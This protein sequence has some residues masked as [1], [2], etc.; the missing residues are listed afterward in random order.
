MPL[1]KII[2]NA[3]NKN[4]NL[5]QNINSRRLSFKPNFNQFNNSFKINTN[6]NAKE[7][8]PRHSIFAFSPKKKMKITEIKQTNN[9]MTHTIIASQLESIKKELENF[10]K[11]ESETKIRIE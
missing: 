7:K 11:N 6:F 4:N 2:I 9:P 10:E 3:T 8:T 5:N 1:I